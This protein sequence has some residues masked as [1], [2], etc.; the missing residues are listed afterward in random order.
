[1]GRVIIV[2][3]VSGSGKSTIGQLLSKDISLPFFDA[4]NFHPKQNLDKMTKGIP[5]NDNDRLPWLKDLSKHISDWHQGE[6]AVLAC[7]AL[8][9]SY[10]IIL[11]QSGAPIDW[12]YLK[13]DFET[14]SKRMKLRKGHFM[15]YTLL[16]SQFDVLEEPMSSIKVSIED[17]A[18]SIVSS[19]IY[20]I[21]PL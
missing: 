18:P 19:I 20:Q 3:G 2:M 9:E 15:N 14:I 1:M 5:L 7:S 16:Q 10:R 4:D 6:G 12:V 13:G 11:A 17:E 21:K 8:K